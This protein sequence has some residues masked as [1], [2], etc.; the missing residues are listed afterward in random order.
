MRVY[1]GDHRIVLRVLDR[2]QPLGQFAFLVV[3]HIRQAADARAIGITRFALPVQVRAQQVAHRLRTV[4]VAALGDQAVELLR[5]RIVQRN[6][7]AFDRGLRAAAFV[8]DN[9]AKIARD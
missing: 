3:V 5:Q 6:G 7:E 4:V 1:G 9:G 2:R 8:A